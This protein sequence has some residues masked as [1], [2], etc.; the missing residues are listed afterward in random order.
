[1]C[2]IHVKVAVLVTVPP[3]RGRGLPP[4]RPEWSD[5]ECPGQA[6]GVWERS[7]ETFRSRVLCPHFEQLCRT[8]AHCDP[9]HWRIFIVESGRQMRVCDVVI[10]DRWANIPDVVN[11]PPGL[12]VGVRPGRTHPVPT[13]I[14]DETGHR[15][16][17][18]DRRSRRR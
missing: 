15:Q 12:V 4:L 5:L 9:G 10:A 2:G 6:S 16:R 14:H 8:W 13:A 11:H 3:T 1:M 18:S 7:A 17:A